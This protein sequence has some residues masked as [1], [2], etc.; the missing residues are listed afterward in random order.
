MSSKPI[1]IIG[2]EPKSIFIEIFLKSIK[3]IKK[4]S[5]PIILISSRDLL[6]KNMK[7]FRKKIRLNQLD[8]EF[9]NLKIDKINLVNIDF[10]NFSFSKRKITNKSN[11]YISKSFNKAIH[12][13]KKKNCAGLINGPISKK[14]FLSGKFNGITEFLAKQTNSR[15]PV[16]LIY[17]KALSVSPLTTHI[18]I[19]KVAKNIK[20][21]NIIL[22]IKKIDN[23]YKKVLKIAPK[24]AVTGLNPHCESFDKENKEKKEIIPAIKH[25]KKIKIKV[26]GPYSSDTI[27]LKENIKKFDVILGM[28]HDQVL[29]P[30][31]TLFGFNAINITLGLPFIRV[32]PDHGPNVQMLG[33]NKSSSKSL[34]ESI[35]FLEKYEI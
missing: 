10:K 14:T 23:F 5:K 12:I 3:K 11:E 21:K 1:V 16:M 26:S 31:K 9:S 7:K 29:G 35:K 30:M 2:G 33:K 27:F 20:K 34:E 19:S 24:I 22:K 6:H 18:P 28:Y 17:N 4:R 25:L 15:D 8:N 32:S 13:L